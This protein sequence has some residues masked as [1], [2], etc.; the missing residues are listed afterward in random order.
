MPSVTAHP[1]K[2]KNASG[3][4][5]TLAIPGDK[6]ISHRALILGGLSIGETTITG[7]LEGEDVL[8]TAEAMRAFGCTVTRGEDGIWSVVGRGVGT[9]AE[10]NRVI[11][12]GNSGTAARLL[13]GM[14]AGHPLT[15]VFSG[16]VSLHRRPMGRI[17]TP[18]T[19]M[20]ATFMARDGGRMPLAVKGSDQ[21]MPIEYRLPVPS[22]QVKSAIMLAALN[23]A[24]TTRVI[25]SEATR[26]HTE[27]ML[28]HFG[29]DVSVDDTDEGR[30]ISLTGHAELKAANVNVSRDPSSAA[31]AIAAASLLPGSNLLLPNIGINPLR[32]GF[33]ETMI[34]MGADITFE[35]RRMEAGEPVADLRVRHA[36]LRGVDVPPERAPSM[37]DEYP[38]LSVVASFAVGATRMTGVKELRVKESDRLAA[39]AAGLNACGV[40]LDEGEDFLI[41]K[42]RQKNSIGGATI[43]ADLDHRIAMSFLVMGLAADEAI[44]IDDGETINT[45]FP[46][47]VS[48]MNEAGA[49]IREG[50]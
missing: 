45:S 15:A 13:M 29:V 11:D 20:G 36:E 7:L 10:P 6:S 1:G 2:D 35:N 9:L 44:K 22:A 5:G 28:R 39:V 38:I 25:E 31:F 43:A 21:P 41:V 8:A 47:F 32:A 12:V 26:D 30:V 37:I 46:G 24:G 16:D 33:I 42:G 40:A 4:T 50:A 49:D 19:K 18:L 23:I 17:I 34:E 3:L 27:H 48:L 14:A